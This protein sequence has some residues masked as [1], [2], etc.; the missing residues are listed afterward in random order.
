MMT[1]DTASSRGEQQTLRE[2][3]LESQGSEQGGIANSPND[4]SASAPGMMNRQANVL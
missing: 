3:T 4:L 2:V 1:D